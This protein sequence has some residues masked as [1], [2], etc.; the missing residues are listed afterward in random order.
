[1]DDNIWP[2]A[3]EDAAGQLHLTNDLPVNQAISYEP[4]NLPYK[5]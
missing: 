1:M 4:T 3:G 5:G 2:A